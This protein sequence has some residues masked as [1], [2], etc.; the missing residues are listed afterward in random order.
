MPPQRHLLFFHIE[1]H[2][3]LDPCTFCV[4]YSS[5]P[6]FSLAVLLDQGITY[7]W[8]W[9]MDSVSLISISTGPKR[10]SAYIY[11]PTY[12]AHRPTVD[13]PSRDWILHMLQ[14]NDQALATCHISLCR[15]LIA[16]TSRWQGIHTRASDMKLRQQS[17][18]HT[19]HAT[20]PSEVSVNGTK[21]TK[22]EVSREHFQNEG[23]FLPLDSVPRHSQRSLSLFLSQD[24]LCVYR[25]TYRHYDETFDLATNL[26]PLHSS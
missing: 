2:E 15:D 5:R 10:R 14:S 25:D 11:A 8:T 7:A 20:Y 9:A 13:P 16:Q 1:H 24:D 3:V 22:D 18:F 19:R 23:Y 4:V 21:L 17:G 26:R 12:N 6:G